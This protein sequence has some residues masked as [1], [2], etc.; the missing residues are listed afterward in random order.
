MRTLWTLAFLAQIALAAGADTAREQLK[1][2]DA[3]AA[4]KTSRAAIKKSDK[5]VAAWIV[6]AEALDA[7]GEPE[8]AWSELEKA[9]EINPKSG[10]L[11]MALGDIYVKLAEKE[12][13]TGK[14]GTTI[15]N[16]FLDALR[17]YDEGLAL[18][19]KLHEALVGKAY[20]Y[21]Q[22]GKPAEAR[23]ALSDCLAMKKDYG[24][25]HALQAYLF[26][27]ERKYAQAL[28]KYEVAVK[29]DKSDAVN[30]V[31]YGHCFLY[32]KPPQPEKALEQYI[33]AL[34]EHPS[35]EAAIRSGIYYL[36]SR[37]WKNAEPYLRQATEQAPKS[38]PAWFWYGYS[39]SVNNQWPAALAA[40]EKADKLSPNNGQYLYYVG[41][42]HENTNNAKKAMEY[43][44]K[45]LKAAPGYAP[46][47]ERIWR[48]AI[49]RVASNFEE[50]E[51][52]CEELLKLAPDNGWTANNYALLLRDWAER[53]GATNQ[54]T[55]KV[56]A[57]VRKRIKRS[58]EVY[59]IAAALLPNEAQIQ[60]DTGLLFEF[61]PVNRDDA[62]AEK[63]FTRS[64]ELS[65]YTYRDAWTGMFR[66]CNRTKNYK[67]LKYTAEGILASLDEA[68]RVPIAPVG[69]RAPAPVP[70]DKPR[71]IAQAR[72]AIA[73]AKKAGVKDEEE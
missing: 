1:K 73:I 39:L 58:G 6:L 22:Q 30:F 43:Y 37:N 36:A 56:P 3:A 68:N 26:Y 15:N 59:E 7:S 28:D 65:E 40:L 16:F 49:A 66:L 18:E 60:S 42:G 5:D 9:I 11:A 55:G 48:L 64:L 33:A 13:V 25:A 63:Y 51:A 46:A 34:K 21:F 41:F 31:R 62:K 69:G 10:R 20:V 29:L 19:P 53:R 4:V 70:N 35:Y 72:Q 47:V 14:D 17:Q 32:L 27:N 52:L 45:S 24:K 61:Y 71:M 44:R 38:A 23:K 8:E 50:A 67:L 12:A 2:G 54:N 57:D